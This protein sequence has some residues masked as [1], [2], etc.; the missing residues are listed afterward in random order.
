MSPA[1]AT[2]RVALVRFVAIAFP[3]GPRV[4]A[5]V[6]ADSHRHSK[7]RFVVGLGSQIKAHHERRFSTPWIAPA[8]RLGEYV[9]SLRAIFRCRTTGEKLTYQQKYYNFFLMTPEFLPG[10]QGLPMPPI[11]M[12]AVGPL[13]L[14]T[15]ARV[16]DSVRPPR[17]ATPA[18]L[19]QVV[20]PLL[21]MELAAS[22]IS[23]ENLEISG[24]GF[25]ATRPDNAAVNDAMEKVEFRVA[26]YGSTTAYRG[27]FDLPGAAIGD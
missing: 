7:G 22:G 9:D 6:A 26:F 16:A 3:P 25:V 24:G 5:N 15:A 13:V 12:A 14:K 23:F 8:A 2:Y 19:Q 20:R 1:L 10:P 17:F 18:Y 21:A 27:A 4:V 11:A